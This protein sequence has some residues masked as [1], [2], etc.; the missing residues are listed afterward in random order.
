[1]KRRSQKIRAVDLFCG[2]GGLTYGLEQAGIRVLAGIDTDEH[3]KFPYEANNTAKFLER[4]IESVTAA[5]II[6]LFP[7]TGYRV[8]VGCAPC[9]PFSTYTQGQYGPEDEQWGLL[10]SF[11][12]IVR[13]V[14]PDVVSME[15]VPQLA[16][17]KIFDEFVYHLRSEGY[18]VS[19]KVVSCVDYGIAQTRH[20]L[21]LLASRHGEVELIPPTHTN[22]NK[23][24]V[25]AKIGKIESV[26]AGGVSKKD[27]LHRA[28]TLSE[29][30][31]KRIKASRPGGTWR[32]W[33]KNLVA[34]CH[35][36]EKGETYPGVYGR[37]E[38]DKP[39]PTITT[40]A[41][42]FGNGRFGHPEQDRALTLREAAILQSFPRRYKF[43]PSKE[44]I[45]FKR[46][47]RLIGNAVP[48]RLGKIVGMTIKKHLKEISRA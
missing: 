5:E 28:S 27:R 2:A 7:K 21:V 35:K 6:R 39:G 18:F 1:M 29:L 32:D 42:G 25:R 37:M 15:N 13:T 30:N 9:Q 16:K 3:C 45:H 19:S 33:D 46:L 22:E 41:Y 36:K 12:R 17:Q 10:A 31:L 48:V 11:S 14:K 34:A 4:D 26:T 40:Q 24:T 8:I 43:V 44:E 23:P 47:G 38:W 20:R